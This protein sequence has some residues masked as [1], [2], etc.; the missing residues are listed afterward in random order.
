MKHV[1]LSLFFLFN[2]IIIF[3][4]RKSKSLKKPLPTSRLYDKNNLYTNQKIREIQ[5]SSHHEFTLIPSC[6][7]LLSFVF[8]HILIMIIQCIVKKLYAI[9]IKVRLTDVLLNDHLN[10]Y[11]FIRSWL[12]QGSKVIYSL[13]NLNKFDYSLKPNITRH[14]KDKVFQTLGLNWDKWWFITLREL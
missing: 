13:I 8:F 3:C 6:S 2:S 11:K 14:N 12:L 4:E 5:L 10:I 9:N 7:T 1:S